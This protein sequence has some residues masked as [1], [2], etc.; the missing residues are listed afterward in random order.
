MLKEEGGFTIIVGYLKN[1][2]AKSFTDIIFAMAD[3]FFPAG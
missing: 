2:W 1:L 3:V